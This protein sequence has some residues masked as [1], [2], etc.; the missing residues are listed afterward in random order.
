MAK[1]QAA[2]ELGTK[3]GKATSAAKA[4]AAKK[5]ASKPRGKWATAIAYQ[6]ASTT[7]E[8]RFGSVVVAGKKAGAGFQEL[9]RIIMQQKHWE[10][11]HPVEE[12]YTWM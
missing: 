2:V 1:N 8:I 10:Q 3:G 9:E 6:Y 5:N 11:A 7:G 4:T 12:F